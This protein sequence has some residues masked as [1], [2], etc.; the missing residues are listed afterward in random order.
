MADLECV[1]R[2]FL[3]QLSD[4]EKKVLRAVVKRVHM[5]YHPE[6]LFTDTMAD[7][8]ICKFGQEYSEKMLKKAIDAG[9][10]N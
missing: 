6:E 8:L 4:K 1:D 10:M 3:D 5:Q 9:L 7:M 2:D